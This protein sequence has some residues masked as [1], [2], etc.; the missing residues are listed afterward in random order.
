MEETSE[1][2]NCLNA[3]FTLLVAQRTVRVAMV[4]VK[5]SS[6]SGTR[7]L[8][9]VGR[10]VSV[11]EIATVEKLKKMFSVDQILKKDDVKKVEADSILCVLFEIFE[12]CSHLMMPVPEA[13]AGWNTVSLLFLNKFSGF[14]WGFLLSPTED[15][16]FVSAARDHSVTSVA[17]SLKQRRCSLEAAHC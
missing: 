17:D 13:R 11:T 14:A 1:Q 12:S 5:R 15:A 16:N 6:L 9:L 3:F 7:L 2:T 8:P 10:D 4:K